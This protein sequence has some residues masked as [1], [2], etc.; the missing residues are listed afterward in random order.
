MK[1]D[2]LGDDRVYIYLV[3]FPG[4]TR[5]IRLGLAPDDRISAFGMRER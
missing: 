4:G 1:R 2:E 5:Y 3:T